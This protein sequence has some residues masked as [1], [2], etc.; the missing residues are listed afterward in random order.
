MAEP[1]GELT[2]LGGWVRAATT[3]RPGVVWRS[4]L[5][6]FYHPEIFWPSDRTWIEG[7][8]LFWPSILL[9]FDHPEIVW[10]AIQV[11][12]EVHTFLWCAVG[13]Q[14]RARQSRGGLAGRPGWPG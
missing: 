13:V 7:H 9:G 10:P 8:K 1:P 2:A 11:R 6:W 5:L 3:G 12:S 4:I 14:T